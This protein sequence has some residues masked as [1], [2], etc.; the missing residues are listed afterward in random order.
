[1]KSR[2]KGNSKNKF[3]T[4]AQMQEHAEHSRKKANSDKH[5][6]IT[7]QKINNVSIKE[8]KIKADTVTSN[9]INNSQNIIFKDKTKNKQFKN[10]INKQQSPD[11]MTSTNN[12]KAKKINN[13][14][15]KVVYVPGKNNQSSK[16]S[17]LKYK[18]KKQKQRE[19]MEE[20]RKMFDAMQAEV[21]EEMK[22]CVNKYGSEDLKK[23][24]NDNS[25][26]KEQKKEALAKELYGDNYEWCESDSLDELEKEYYDEK[27]SG[28]SDIFSDEYDV[29][30]SEKQQNTVVQRK[31]QIE[32][33]TRG[34]SRKG[35]A[36]LGDV[37][38]K[39]DTELID[40]Q[41]EH[42]QLEEKRKQ[43]AATISL[44]NTIL[45]VGLTIEDY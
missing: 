27:I 18:E 28:K 17:T 42:Q 14:S 45:A 39:Q 31:P 41:Q 35:S 3:F 26:T 19:E 7:G 16:K 15:T 12:E 37:T 22:E 9:D 29:E 34:N 21:I 30:N 33:D 36:T 38:D 8:V 5:K 1:M 6:D 25:S 23:V 11:Q 20:I 32:S 4:N 44:F 43:Q 10:E 24:Y 13:K 40:L 2:Y